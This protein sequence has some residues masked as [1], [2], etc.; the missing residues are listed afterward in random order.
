MK[1]LITGGAGF[2]GSHLAEELIIQANQVVVYDNLRT[3]NLK[4]L[5]NLPVAL[6]KGDVLDYQSL[7]K[8]MHGCEI[9]FHLAAL[10]SVVESMGN[11]EEY[12]SVNL[13]GTLNVLKAAKE[14]QVNKIIF[15]SSAAV[16]GDS[17]E[18]PKTEAMQLNPKSPYAITKLDSEYY[19]GL[20]NE[21]YNLPTVCGR[22]FNVFGERQAPDSPYAAAIP[23]FISSCLKSDPVKIYGDGTQV[24]DFIYVKDLVKAFILLMEKGTGVFNIGYGKQVTINSVVKLIKDY[25]NS[26]SEIC[27]TDERP[28]EIKNSFSSIDKL[29]S[30]GFKPKFSFENGLFRTIEYYKN[31]LFLPK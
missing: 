19:C 15:A 17:P 8:A 26:R 30:L 9:V 27:F 12:V 20:Y 22:F 1:I 25:L 7:T 24:R 6:V 31:G 21:Y 14:N 18:L 23:L 29:V 13:H 3:G 16:Y 11:I 2:I 5:I 4:N 28:G 10:T